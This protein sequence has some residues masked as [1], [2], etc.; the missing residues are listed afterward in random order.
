MGIGR[1]PTPAAFVPAAA[2][3]SKDERITIFCN[4]LAVAIEGF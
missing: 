1:N 3:A 4:H 2:D